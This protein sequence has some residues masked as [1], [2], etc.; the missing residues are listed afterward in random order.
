[1]LQS[2]SLGFGAEARYLAIGIVGF[3]WLNNLSVTEKA[4]LR[5]IIHF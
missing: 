3:L 1:M 5:L 4:E 2:R